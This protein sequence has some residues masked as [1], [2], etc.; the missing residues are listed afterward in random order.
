MND[1]TIAHF[2]RKGYRIFKKSSPSNFT[3]LENK[4]DSV[5]VGLKSSRNDNDYWLFGTV[6]DTVFQFVDGI[7]VGMSKWKFFQTVGI[8]FSYNQESFT[9]I[10]TSMLQSKVS[11]YY[12]LYCSKYKD[13]IYCQPESF[14]ASE[15][16]IYFLRF[17]RNRISEIKVHS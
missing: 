14:Y 3:L 4:K 9:I 13:E 15:Y 12:H 10:M 2:Y 6:R 16:L 11:W 8:D 17:K 7:K 1:S 5:V